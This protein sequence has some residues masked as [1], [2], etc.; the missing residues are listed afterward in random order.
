MS[1]LLNAGGV[2]PPKQNTEEVGHWSEPVTDF[3]SRVADVL[4]EVNFLTSNFSRALMITDLAFEFQPGDGSIFLEKMPDGFLKIKPGLPPK[5]YKK[6]VGEKFWSSIESKYESEKYLVY[7]D[8]QEKD[9]LTGLYP[10]FDLMFEKSPYIK[11]TWK[12]WE[13][14]GR[15][16]LNIEFKSSSEYGG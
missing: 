14:D 11:F 8:E 6:L 12:T 9:P 2:E 4:L 15:P 7:D 5:E 13:D 16:E 1:N 10:E 3:H